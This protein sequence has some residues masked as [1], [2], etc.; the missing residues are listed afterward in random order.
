MPGSQV[1][2]LNTNF[3]VHKPASLAYNLC[4]TLNLPSKHQRRTPKV[5]ERLYTAAF[6]LLWKCQYCFLSR[7]TNGVKRPLMDIYVYLLPN[8]R[9]TD[10]G[11][12][13]DHVC[14]FL[15]CGALCSLI[16]LY[17]D[18]PAVLMVNLL[19]DYHNVLVYASTWSL[20]IQ[21]TTE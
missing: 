1:I 5:S 21:G 15:D 18:N 7:C 10:K 8:S 19:L 3:K 13:L 9:D 17:L 2:D 20:V 16:T 11:Q 14:I 4:L 6:V 12:G